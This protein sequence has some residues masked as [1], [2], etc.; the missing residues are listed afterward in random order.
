[1]WCHLQGLLWIPIRYNVF[2]NTLYP[3]IWN[4]FGY[5]C[6]ADQVIKE[7]P[8]VVMVRG[9]SE[10]I[11][12]LKGRFV[13]APVFSC[14]DFDKT[15]FLQTDASFSGVGAVPTQGGPNGE[16]V[17]AYASKFLTEPEKKYSVTEKEHLAVL[18][19]IRKFRPYLEECQFFCN[20]WSL[21]PEMA[22]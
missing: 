22:V 12:D 1:M 7:K 2:W 11:W 17:I 3:R 10:F 4:N 14:P 13:K 8:K 5:C 15:F 16:Q 18:W 6:T 21:C 19:T 9:S 20:H